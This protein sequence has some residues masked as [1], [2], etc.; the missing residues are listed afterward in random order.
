ML[1]TNIQALA[2]FAD[3]EA[4]PNIGSILATTRRYP[5]YYRQLTKCGCTFVLN[6]LHH[7]DTGEVNEDPDIVHG[8]GS[9]IV[10]A[11][12]VDNVTIRNSPYSF[13]VT[14]HPVARF[15]SLYFD[16]IVG[17]KHGR[18]HHIGKLFVEG[19]IVDPDAGDAVARHRDNVHRAMDWI[20]R[21]LAGETGE[22][23]NWHWKP[24]VYRLGQVYPFEFHVL[25][26][27]GLNDQL[28]ALLSPLVPDIAGAMTRVSPRNR[29][30][31]PVD[32]REVVDP[33]LEE[34]IAATYPQDLAVHREVSAHWSAAA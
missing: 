11:G 24:Q 33:E 22:P 3:E 15:F 9:P 26:L 8:K 18:R 31:R 23:V 25:T 32:W 10:S 16:K 5:L 6:V 19:G 13:I 17:V 20:G 12:R 29:S 21:N 4:H 30:R 2:D 28:P 7:L 14:R 34:K 27:E 1:T